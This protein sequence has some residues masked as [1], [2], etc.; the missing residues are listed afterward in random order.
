M[1]VKLCKSLI[2]ICICSLVSQYYVSIITRQTTV[3]TLQQKLCLLVSIKHY[4]LL[5]LNDL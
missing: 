1:F 5:H 4:E 3:D 2:S